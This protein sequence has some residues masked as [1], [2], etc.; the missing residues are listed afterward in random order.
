MRKI[1]KFLILLLSVS[2]FAVAGSTAQ[3]VV[4]KIPVAPRVRQFARPTKYHLWV[5]D[6]WRP[7]GDKYV[8][9]QGY[10]GIPPTDFSVWKKGYWNKVPKGYV[11]IN[12]YWETKYNRKK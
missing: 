9:A 1:N 6:E 7:M 5:S 8:F 3:V 10:W 2:L 11:F 4:S 12:G